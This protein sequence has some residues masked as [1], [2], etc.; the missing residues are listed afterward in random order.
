MKGGNMRDRYK[1]LR[2]QNGKET[3]QIN[4]QRNN[5]MITVCIE[6][7]KEGAIATV[8]RH[9]LSISAYR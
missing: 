7:S 4:R 2:S 6:E 5:S 8:N 1:D 3:E 9:F